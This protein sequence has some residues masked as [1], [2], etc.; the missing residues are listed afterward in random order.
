MLRR[1]VHFDVLELVLNLKAGVV[2]GRLLVSRGPLFLEVNLVL[3]SVDREIV[4]SV[5]KGLRLKPLG[6][7]AFPVVEDLDETGLLCLREP[8]HH[9]THDEMVALLGGRRRRQGHDE[10]ATLAERGH[11]G[12]VGIA[13]LA[14]RKP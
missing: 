3:E 12:V 9:A 7:L 10:A 4:L 11:A 8:P 14:V 1:E 2:V 6:H 13:A 5:L